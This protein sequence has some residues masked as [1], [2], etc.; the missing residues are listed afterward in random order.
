MALTGT[1]R[2]SGATNTGGQ[3]TLVVTPTSN[4]T[5]GRSLA[6][7]CVAYDNSGGGGSDPFSSITDSEGNVWTS[8]QNA[9]IDPAGPNVGHVLRIFTSPMNSGLLTTGDTIT[10]SFGGVTTV[11]RSWTLME[12]S[13]TLSRINYGTGATTTATTASPTITTSSITSG[14]MVIGAVGA[15]SG[16]TQVFTGDADASSGSWS[17]QQTAS[18]GTTTAGSGITSQLKV[19]T[20][21]ATQTYNPTL[22]ISSDLCVAWISLTEVDD[23]ADIPSDPF[24]PVIM[25]M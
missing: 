3:T 15:E 24:P 4:F 16:T 22:S 10:V 9:L 17:T 1:D 11:A 13:T 8:R 12:V 21:T 5:G 23:M 7:L 19:T 20:G 18:A 2:G 6:V 25:A 14:D